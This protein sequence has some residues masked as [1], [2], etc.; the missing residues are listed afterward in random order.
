MSWDAAVFRLGL[1]CQLLLF[2]CF[3]GQQSTAVQRLHNQN[4]LGLIFLCSSFKGFYS[5][6]RTSQ[7][8]LFVIRPTSRPRILVALASLQGWWPSV[9][10]LHMVRISRISLKLNK[11][12]HL[13][14]PF[15]MNLERQQLCFDLSDAQCVSTLS[16]PHA[17]SQWG[18]R[19]GKPR[20]ASGVHRSSYG[21]IRQSHKN[22]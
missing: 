13:H 21:P 4:Q 12:R 20:A 15:R 22:M 17:L 7:L 18:Q 16:Y 11:P 5:L 8:F 10:W 9:L 1:C 14:A 19:P 2:G 3:C 6:H